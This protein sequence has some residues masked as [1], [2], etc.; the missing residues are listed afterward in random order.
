MV[1]RVFVC[2]AYLTI[3]MMKVYRGRGRNRAGMF[4]SS[5][6]R[7]P[8]F[9]TRKYF[10]A[11]VTAKVGARHRFE[12]MLCVKN[13]RTSRDRETLAESRG[14]AAPADRVALRTGSALLFDQEARDISPC[15]PDSATHTRPSHSELN[16]LPHLRPHLVQGGPTVYKKAKPMTRRK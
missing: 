9:S 3:L 1:P 7:Q 4:P 6:R 13:T 16:A 10:L 12:E 14:R 11:L 2:F 15:R 5:L 8:E